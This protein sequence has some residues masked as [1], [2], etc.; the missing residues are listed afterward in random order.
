MTAI[1]SD[2]IKKTKALGYNESLC[3]KETIC[4]L[5]TKTGWS[6][7]VP[8]WGTCQPTATCAKLCYAAVP[9]KPITWPTSLKKN[10]RVLNYFLTTPTAVAA[11]RIYKEY[12]GQK[13]TF[14]RWNGVGDLIPETV[15][16]INYLAKHHPEMVQWVVTRKVDMASFITRTGPNVYLMFSL[17]DSKQSIERKKKI[18]RS[19]HPRLYYSYLKQRDDEDTMGARIIFNM[20]QKKKIL[21]HNSAKLDCPVDSG[22]I[23]VHGACEACRKCFSP[24]VYK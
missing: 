8:I 6:V 17:D 23:P 9:G 2:L 16:V 19:R 18:A 24:G 3:P 1:V 15:K 5:N 7:N 20:Q 12:V 10:I 4:S 14:I 22:K 21:K 13:M 11:E